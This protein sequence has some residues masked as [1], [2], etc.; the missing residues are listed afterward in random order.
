MT[1]HVRRYHRHDQSTGHVGQGRFQAFPIQG[2]DHLRIV[3]RYVERNPLRAA[4][5]A[6][7]QDWPW[8]SLRPADAPPIPRID[9]GTAPRGPGWL[10]QVNRIADPDDRLPQIRHG[11]QRGTPLGSQPR[12]ART[13]DALGLRSS[14]RTRGRPPKRPTPARIRH[15]RPPEIPADPT[16]K[17]TGLTSRGPGPH[18]RPATPPLPTPGQ[19]GPPRDP[20]SADARSQRARVHVPSRARNNGNGSPR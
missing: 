6:R 11:I 2:D 13:A 15:P 16:T 10:D 4:L 3:L 5:L 19:V 7:A 9:P 12:T 17:A 1:S 8:S 18:R 14:T 20:H